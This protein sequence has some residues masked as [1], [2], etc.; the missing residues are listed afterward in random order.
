MNDREIRDLQKEIQNLKEQ[1]QEED[2]RN[3]TRHWT[4]KKKTVNNNGVD[5]ERLDSQSS[6][7][8]RE[9]EKKKVDSKRRRVD[10]ED[11]E[12]IAYH[13]RMN[14]AIKALS[15]DDVYKH[16]VNHTG[17]KSYVNI[18]ELAEFL[19]MEPIE[20]EDD[21][22][23]ELIARYLV[24]DNYDDFVYFDPRL[25]EEMHIVNSRIRNLIGNYE[26][27]DKEAYVERQEELKE[28][29]VY[30]SKL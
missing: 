5:M 26:V 20:M 13:T 21:K 28:V 4:N 2:F 15:L 6:L 3:S 7:L 27:L 23:I 22:Q 25:E 14:L 12:P 11:V 17:N 30:I 18:E 29:R 19:K 10:Y 16:L 24:E 8:E 9:L 1:R